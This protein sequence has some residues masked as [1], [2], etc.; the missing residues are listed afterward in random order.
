MVVTQPQFPFPYPVR[1]TSVASDK[2]GFFLGLATIDCDKPT[3]VV[4]QASGSCW[5]ET[6]VPNTPL[7]KSTR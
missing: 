4:A 6:G 5:L 3:H 7:W 2:S 1:L